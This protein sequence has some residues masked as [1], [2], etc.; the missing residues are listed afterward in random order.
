[1]IEC[2]RDAS[3]SILYGKSLD[4]SDNTENESTVLSTF[5]LIFNILKIYFIYFYS[6]GRC[7]VCIVNST[8]FFSP[9]MYESVVEQ[10][11]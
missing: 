2:M 5:K 8:I 11:G 10:D 4:S 1:M 6:D 7:F 3:V 9:H